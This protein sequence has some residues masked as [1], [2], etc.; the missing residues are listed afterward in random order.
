MNFKIP[1][2]CVGD[3]SDGIFTFDNRIH[4]V[5]DGE[6]SVLDS[7][8]YTEEDIRDMQLIA[9]YAK[10]VDQLKNIYRKLTDSEAKS[11]RKKKKI[12]SVKSKINL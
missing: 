8:L 11:L 7:D 10:S 12:V 3:E 4:V 9:E 1:K 2:F 6:I 5:I